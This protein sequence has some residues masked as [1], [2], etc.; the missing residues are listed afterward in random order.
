VVISDSIQ[1]DSVP[2]LVWGPRV[3]LRDGLRVQKSGARVPTMVRLDASDETSGLDSSSL[4]AI[5]GGVTRASDYGLAGKAGLNVQIDR[6]G[7]TLKGA[8]NDVV[9][10]RTARTLEPSVGLFDARAASPRIQLSGGWKTSKHTASLGKTLA[11]TASRGATAKLQLQGAQFALVAR[12]GPAGGRLDV[13]VDGEPVTTIDLYAGSADSRRI[14]YV[15][16]VPR[17]E[18]ELKLRATGTGSAR[19]AVPTVWLDAILVLDRRK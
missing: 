15:G 18:H 3:S 11:R 4:E 8:A 12:R 1:L 7:C 9:G 2:P 17:G 19:S 13:I 6:N 5:C 14:V 16:N 10:H